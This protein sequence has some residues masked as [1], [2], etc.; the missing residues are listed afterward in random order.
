MRYADIH[1]MNVSDGPGIGVSVYVQGCELHCTGCFNPSTW[2]VH[3]GKEWEPRAMYK[4]LDLLRVPWM[5]RLSI[6]GGEPLRLCNYVALTHLI[7]N[8]RCENCHKD[9]FE[10]WL[11]TGRVY[12]DVQREA[13]DNIHL[14]HLLDNIDVIVDGPFVESLK[15]LTLEWRGSSNQRVIR[16]HE[17]G[18]LN[19]RCRRAID[20]ARWLDKEEA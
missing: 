9:D 5:T 8:A 15:D 2:D 11:W 13:Q 17:E 4:V 18:E 19:E 6:L 10:V 1:K 3:G 7:D 20:P 16:L 14:A 12:E